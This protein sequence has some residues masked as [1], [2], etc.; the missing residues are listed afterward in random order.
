VEQIGELTPN[1]T[2]HP[3][4]IPIFLVRVNE[5]FKGTLPPDVNEKILKVEW[6]SLADLLAL[7]RDGRVHCG[8]TKAALCQYLAHIRV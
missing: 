2:F 6:K 5:E 8:M 3:H 7:I 1:T 4:R